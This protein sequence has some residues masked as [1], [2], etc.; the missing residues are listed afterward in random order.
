MAV[1][2]ETD[3][4]QT[5][6]DEFK[7]AIDDGRVVTWSYD[8]DGDFTHTAEQWKYKAWFRPSVEDQKLAMYIIPPKNSNISSEVYAIYHGRF[9]ESVLV[10]CD[11][12]FKN[13]VATSFP[14]GSDRVSSS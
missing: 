3:T 7:K 2:F 6:L 11:K 12:F 4:P 5:L 1:Y 14:K 8:V 13:S 9:I 10:H